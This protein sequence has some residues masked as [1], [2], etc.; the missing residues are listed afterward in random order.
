MKLILDTEEKTLTRHD[1]GASESIPLYSRQAFE[2]LSAEWLKIGWDQKYSYTMTWLGRP[3]IQLPEDMIRVQEVIWSTRPDVIV[4]TGIAHG[5]S[6][7]F[8]ASLCKLLGKGRVIG[9]DIE[10][11]PHNRAAL[12][13]HWLRDHI[14]LIEGSSVDPAIVEKV[15]GLIRPGESVLVILDSNHCKAH[16]LAELSAYGPLVTSGSYLVATDGIQG[17]LADVPDGRPEWHSDNPSAAALEFAANHPEFT[18]G[19][20]PWLF[21]ESKLRLNV[22]YWPNAWLRRK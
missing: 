3:V 14:T 16:V 17:S 10:I 5:G 19:Q 9:V 1:G 12:D 6:L 15:R 13:T 11:R 22:T 20:P 8:Y 2:W 7:V 21:N 4:E 18:L